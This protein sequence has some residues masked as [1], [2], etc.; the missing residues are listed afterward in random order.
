MI[1]EDISARFIGLSDA[2]VAKRTLAGQTNRDPRSRTKDLGAI[3]AE[4]LLTV[5]NVINALIIGL[6]AWLFAV[7]DDARLLLDSV[8]ILSV[9]IA[10][11][12]IAIVQE[13]RAHRALERALLTMTP[14]AS[15]I[16]NDEVLSINREDV[17]VDDLLI[18]RRGDVVAADAEVIYA[19]GLEL[20][21]SL[22]TGESQPAEATPGRTVHA[23]THCTAGI[24][25]V[26]VA[27]VGSD[28]MAARITAMAKRYSFA[29][30]PMQRTVN[31]LFEGW[32]VFAVVMAAIEV[33]LSAST[34][35]QDVDEI[36]RIATLL[37]G[38]I[39]EGLVFFA[40]ITV[41]LSVVR[42]TKKGVVVQKLSALES[43]ASAEVV[44]MDKTGTLTES[45]LSVHGVEPLSE[46]TVLDC[47]TMLRSYADASL[48]EGQTIDA[49]KGIELIDHQ[50]HPIQVQKFNPSARVAFS[51]VRKYSALRIGEP[52]DENPWLV[53][54]SADSV[55]TSSH[56]LWQDVM[57]RAAARGWQ[58][59]RLVLLAKA[60]DQDGAPAIGIAATPICWCALD[61]TVRTDAKDA[62]VLFSEMGVKVV[63]LTGDAP[64]PV[65]SSLLQLGRVIE[66]SE[67]VLG[68]ELLNIDKKTL[69]HFV[70]TRTIFARLL[71]D[72]KRDIVNAFREESHTVMIGDGVNDLPAIK[73]ADVGI[74]M[75]K[76]AP[77]TKEIA[78]IVLDKMS[79][80]ALPE[81][82]GEGRAVMRTVLNVAK[83][84]IGKNSILVV[85]SLV[86]SAGLIPFPLTPRRG[87]L[88]SILGVGIPSMLLAAQ[89][90]L[91]APVRSF[92]K[93]LVAFV[94]VCATCAVTL[95]WSTH[96][97]S[98]LFPALF[99]SHAMALTYTLI[100]SLIGSFLSVDKFDATT[101]R[102][103]RVLAA[104]LLA[105]ALG[106]AACPHWVPGVNIIQT[107]YEVEHVS[108]Q[109]VS[110]LM[111]LSA[112]ALY[113]SSTVHRVMLSWISSRK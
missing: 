38:L 17:V 110:I 90:R 16:R 14:R 92:A 59:L 83:L 42:I 62:L 26:R 82:V 49:L 3:V 37:V 9:V 47:S 87:A 101:T 20:D 45:R 24:G 80:T 13:V 32:F 31:R 57:G 75:E 10:N 74:A 21:E 79:F 76:S 72:Q 95:S 58:E 48:D 99:H 77:I 111:C 96:L 69:A 33:V 81:M 55:L 12:L 107:F 64:G 46:S 97:L 102:H 30:S 61:D 36:R 113:A 104:I 67:I 5:F 6:L 35:L 106:L 34:I 91:R 18:V 23:A 60:A 94:V 66:P 22:L 39:P 109:Q 71:P 50:G 28:S 84:F 89:G 100:G 86:A 52:L 19:E 73:A 29:P 103:T 78:D 51:S 25:V 2:D 44:C 112:F 43:F 85:M 93:E 68:P 88:L 65:V 7:N 40:T 4:N 8:G 11:T 27:H 70:S 41:T 53:L 63:F 108:I 15:V 105:I 54:G 98:V 1:L 56:P